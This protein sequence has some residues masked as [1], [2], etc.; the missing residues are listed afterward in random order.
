MQANSNAIMVVASKAPLDL[1]SNLAAELENVTLQKG[2]TNSRFR[3]ILIIREVQM[4]M[5][6]PTT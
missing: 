6:P 4:A 1:P 2:L 3:L 5:N